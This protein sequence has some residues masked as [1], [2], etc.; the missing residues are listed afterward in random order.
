MNVRRCVSVLVFVLMLV[1]LVSP[2]GAQDIEPPISV[3][4]IPPIQEFLSFVASPVGAVIVGAVV[5]MYLER[6]QWYNA[7]G[8]E[9]KRLIAY[10]L[11]AFVAIAAYVLVTYVPPSFWQSLAPYWVIAAFTAFAVFGNQGWFQLAIRRARAEVSVGVAQIER[12]WID[13]DGDGGRM[14]LGELPEIHNQP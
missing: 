4:E 2:V 7:Q 9:T 5:S 14:V 11:T 6:W 13:E 1:L 12:E 8:D 3:E 10:G